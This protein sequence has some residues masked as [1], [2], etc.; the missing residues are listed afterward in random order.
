MIWETLTDRREF[1]EIMLRIEDS[2]S[3]LI[4]DPEYIKLKA[5]FIK[6]C[7]PLNVMLMLNWY[8]TEE[9]WNN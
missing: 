3:P 1:L 9:P 5:N 6:M 4:N 2:Y 7:N 8:H